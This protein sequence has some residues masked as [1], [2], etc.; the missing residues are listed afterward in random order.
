M[1][2]EWHLDLGE[3]LDPD[4]LLGDITLSDAQTRLEERDTYIDSWLVALIT[5]LQAVQAGQSISVDIPEEPAPLDFIP[6]SKEV[7]IAYRTSV[8]S[9]CDFRVIMY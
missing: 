3:A 7:H 1:K 6:V 8:L 5:G 2:I 4:N 9:N